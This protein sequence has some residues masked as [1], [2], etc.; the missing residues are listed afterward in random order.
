MGH[1]NGSPSQ[2]PGLRGTRHPGVGAAHTHLPKTGKKSNKTRD[3]SGG[4]VN[5]C[6]RQT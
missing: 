2:S 1:A 5:F 3:I 4:R 6:V